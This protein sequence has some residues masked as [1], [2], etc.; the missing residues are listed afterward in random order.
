MFPLP[1][2]NPCRVV[3]AV[4]SVI[5]TKEIRAREGMPCISLALRLGGEAAITIGT[6]RLD[7]AADHITLIPENTPYTARYTQNELLFVHFSTTHPLYTVPLDRPLRHPERVRSLFFK[8]VEAYGRRGLGFQVEAD[9]LL[10]QL[11]VECARD[12]QE[13]NAVYRAACAVMQERL[14][15]SALSVEGIAAAV[16][17]SPS[18]LRRLFQAGCGMSPRRRLN[19]MRLDRAAQ[20]LATEKITVAETAARCGFADARYF[21]RVCRQRRHCTPQ[22]LR[23]P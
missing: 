22:Q 7:S 13:E 21:A 9:A 6:E 12:E 1:E 16:G 10:M 20:L 11:L 17:V 23:F 4:H 14:G 3:S 19:E 15:D 2:N 18:Q 8:L 5:D